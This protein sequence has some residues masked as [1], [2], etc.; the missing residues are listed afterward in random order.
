MLAQHLITKP[1]FDALFEGY[2]FAKNNPVSKAMQGVVEV[3]SQHHLEKEADTLQKFYDSVKQRAE[4]IDDIKAKQKIIIELYDK[5]FK[6]A[7]PKMTERLGIVYTPIEVVDFI[8]H[9]VNDALKS[10]FGQTL[11]SENVHIIDPFTGTGTFITRLMQSG[12]IS[13]EQLAHKYTHEIHANEIV[14]L[15]YYIAAINIESVY[16]DIMGGDYKPFNGICLTDT[17]ALYE[18]GD[19][20]S[21]I[22]TDNSARRKRQKKL[23]LRVIIG[24]PPYSI[25]QTSAN[26]DN[27]NVSYPKLDENIAE[28]YAKNSKAALSKGLYDSYIRSIRWASDRIKDAGVIGFVSGSGFL[29]KSAMDGLRKSLAQEF[30]SIY[31]FNLRGDIRKNMLS[32][33]KAKE[34]QNV[35]RSGSMTGTAITLFIKNPKAKETGKIYYYDIGDDLKTEEKLEKISQLK[36]IEGN[37][38]DNLWQEI[39]PDSHGDWLNQRDESFANHISLGDKKDKNSP[40]IF[41]NY[42]LGVATNRDA[43]CYNFSKNQLAQNM[44]VM[45]EFYNS[46]VLRYKA[47]CDGLAK[48]NFPKIDDFV[49]SDSTKIS[50]SRALKKDLS[51]KKD[52]S[53]QK[54]CLVFASYRPFTKQWMYFN[55]QFNEMVLQMPQIFPDASV[56]NLVICVS[57]IGARSGFSAL[58]MNQISSLDTI[59]K[60]QCFP[61]KLFEP[62]KSQTNSPQNQDSSQLA[63][64]VSQD[65]M[66]DLAS[67]KIADLFDQKTEGNFVVK[68][69]ITDAGLAHFSKNYAGEKIS[70]EDV[71]Y[72]IYGLLHSEDYKQRFADNLTKELPRIPCVKK[73]ADFWH[74]SKAGRELAELHINYENVSPF[75]ANFAGGNLAIEMLKDADFRVEKMK[76]AKVGKETDKT[77]VIYNSK[78]TV[79]NIPLEAYDYVVNGKPAIEWVM[80]RQGISTHK[81][82]G[83]VNDANLWAIETMN[84]ARYPLDLLLRVITVSIETIK[85]VRALPRLEI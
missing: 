84:N 43:W 47:A 44:S 67:S 81:E 5:F 12:L 78:I 42:S 39:L 62:K 75:A 20:I 27:Q 54:N 56:E 13:K 26:D 15:A 80:E 60:G 2:S 74:F 70:K 28:T 63:K 33:G 69:G 31:A 9:S 57:G 66:F 16:H 8:I 18:K 19:M 30:S 23:D 4:K 3:L 14:L 25:G 83:I 35:F 37:L 38:A 21:D 11:G 52:A 71:F 17:F 49:A 7:F 58:M 40:V 6:N 41:E 48:E 1:V 46:E 55:R 77:K 61:L 79:E 73:A 50:W 24:N 51:L 64:P 10:E 29:E 34:G 82:S 68:D 76:F 72:Y 45:I 22:F 32:K 65:E 36:S 85:I 59:E 53:F